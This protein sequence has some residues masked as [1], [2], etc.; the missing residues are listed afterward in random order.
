MGHLA[1]DELKHPTFPES[2]NTQ[3]KEHPTSAFFLKPLQRNQRWNKM[4]SA[5]MLRNIFKYMLKDNAVNVPNISLSETH[6]HS[7]VL[8][9]N[10]IQAMNWMANDMTPT[11]LMKKIKLHAYLK[12]QNLYHRIVIDVYLS[13]Y[14]SYEYLFIHLLPAVQHIYHI[15]HYSWWPAANSH[16]RCDHSI[17]KCMDLAAINI[18]VLF[19]KHLQGMNPAINHF[20]QSPCVLHN[21]TAKLGIDTITHTVPENQ[22]R[23]FICHTNNEILL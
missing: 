14:W 6:F 12:T 1:P 3:H 8:F 17:K 9:Y 7:Y 18:G 13:L 19:C 4:V 2:L 5:G 21:L 22:S 15:I 11:K 20:T 23:N 10:F 16:L